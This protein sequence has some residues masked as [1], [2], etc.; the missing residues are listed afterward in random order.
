M[1]LRDG[2]PS[3]SLSA[4]GRPSGLHIG[5]ER[6]GQHDAS[7]SRTMTPGR[8]TVHKLANATFELA[9]S[10]ARIRVAD[11]IK[12]MYRHQL[13]RLVRQ[14]SLQ[15]IASPYPARG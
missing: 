3:E 11:G 7:L 15:E 2:L 8:K 1:A 5:N 9:L 6:T 14:R 12:R 4:N 13:R 10:D